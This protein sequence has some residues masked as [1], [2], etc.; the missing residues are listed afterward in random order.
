MRSFVGVL[1]VVWALS[2]AGLPSVAAGEKPGNRLNAKACQK[3]GY[4]TLVT[5]TGGTFTSESACVSYAASGGKLL[6]KPT[7]TP[8][9]SGG[10]QGLI[11]DDGASFADEAAC[12]AYVSV[13]TNRVFLLAQAHCVEPG[14]VLRNKT[15]A[16]TVDRWSQTCLDQL[17]ADNLTGAKLTKSYDAG[18]DAVTVA[19]SAFGVAQSPGGELP[20]PCTSGIG[21]TAIDVVNATAYT[22]T[23]PLFVE[24]L[25]APPLTIGPDGLYSSTRTLTCP[26]GPAT[27]DDILAAT[28][29][30]QTSS[31]TGNLNDAW[32]NHGWIELEVASSEFCGP[33]QAFVN[34]APTAFDDSITVP[35]AGSCFDAFEL[36]V[37]DSDPEGNQ[38]RVRPE[39]TGGVS[40]GTVYGPGPLVGAREICF[41]PDASDATADSF[42]YTVEDRA[43]LSDIGTVTVTID[44]S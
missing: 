26:V 4:L 28:S 2:L 39:S 20:P 14:W 15:T 23:W 10:W 27:A 3:G 25:A 38:L 9:L 31:F 6:P 21:E 13:S 12:T 36:T 18:T 1:M 40:H 41:D 8:C 5:S 17:A 42:T 44:R 32:A 30:H 34:T 16:E 33:L 24:C 7:A 29:W 37:N 19:V 22:G 43:G 35:A 11:T